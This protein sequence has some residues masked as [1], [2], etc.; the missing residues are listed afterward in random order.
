[1]PGPAVT[2]NDT[3]STRTVLLLAANP[4]STEALD[5]EVEREAIERALRRAPVHQALRVIAKHSV[6]DDDLRRA[7]LDHEPEIVHFSGHGIGMRGLVFEDAAEPLLISGTALAGLLGLCSKHVKCV[8]LNACYS[9]VQAQAISP[10]VEYVIGM[11]RA[12]GDRA[13]I[14][15][16]TGFYD[17]LASGRSYTDAFHFGCNAISLRGIPESLT[18][19]LIVGNRIQSE[20][21]LES[22]DKTGEGKSANIRQVGAVQDSSVQELISLLDFRA[23]L[24]LKEMSEVERQDVDVTGN[25]MAERDRDM[26]KLWESEEELART[27]AELHEQNKKALLDRQF[28]LS[29]EITRQIQQFLSR[30]MHVNPSLRATYLY[31][32]MAILSQFYI[33]GNVYPGPLPGSLKQTPIPTVLMW[34][35]EEEEQR[36]LQEE[37][38]RAQEVAIREAS[39]RPKRLQDAKALRMKAIAE[40]VLIGGDRCPWCHFA[41]AWN[42]LDCNHCHFHIL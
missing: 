6:T 2:M 17:A 21:N 31:F 27:F 42:G 19:T 35:R 20:E 22:A 16:S 5:L 36:T 18:P 7:L 23:D 30:T 13:A 1:M 39:D 34:K 26:N 41:Y 37:K 9:E 40:G 14:K 25:A 33:S 15:F 11:S 28:V 32:K 38:T 12:I 4:A 10:V 8:V 3:C 24:V 29:H